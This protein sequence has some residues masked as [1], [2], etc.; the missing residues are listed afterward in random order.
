[1]AI[2]LAPLPYKQDDLVPYISAETVDFH[3]NK[4]HKGYVDKLNAF[5]EKD[6]SL[7]S[8]TLEALI[9]EASPGNLFN[10]VAQ[11]W[12]HSFYW[13][14]LSPEGG[15]TPSGT[16]ADAIHD[17][18]GSFQEFKDEF[19]KKATT[20]FGSG[21]VWLVQTSQTLKIVSTSNAQTPLTTDEKPLLTCDV[22]EHAYYI[23][24]RNS[25]PRYMEA[26]W[27]LIHWD[28]ALKNL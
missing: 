20:T 9:K 5:L 3:Y 4:H 21:W 13:N 26:F 1:M 25:R 15:G 27:N 24:Y 2:E 6:P 23:D 19:T 7:A 11:T 12:N 17:S 14:S 16:L 28:F 10:N 22:W 18:F 8:K